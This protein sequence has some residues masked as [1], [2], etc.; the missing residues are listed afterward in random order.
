M[1]RRVG[2]VVAVV[3]ALAGA[4][5]ADSSGD[6][7]LPPTA[8]A[9]VNPLTQGNAWTIYLQLDSCTSNRTECPTYEAASFIELSVRTATV[10]QQLTAVVQSRAQWLADDVPVVLSG[11]EQPDGAV[12]YRGRYQ[13]AIVGSAFRDVDVQD[14]TLRAD[15]RS[16]LTGTLLMVDSVQF[17]SGNFFTKTVRA[18]VRSASR[19]ALVD[20]PQSFQGTFDGFGTLSACDGV[21]PNRAVGSRTSVALRLTQSG[22]TVTGELGMMKVSGTAGASSLSLSGEW[23]GTLDV[24]G[25]GTTVSRLESFTATTDALGRLTGTMRIYNEGVY[26]RQPGAITIATPFTERLTWE[27]TT[28]VRR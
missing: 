27:L 2:L 14:L 1:T 12:R 21:C 4:A 17:S 9:P 11:Q 6:A 28:V 8:P 24:S 22:T 16:G 13:S 10:G 23:R 20:P 26:D 7:V 5:C 3:T 25:L 18:T 15:D 19:Q